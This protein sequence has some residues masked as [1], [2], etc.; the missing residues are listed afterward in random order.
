M[1]EAGPSTE[2]GKLPSPK[3][4]ISETP[5]QVP[6]PEAEILETP[7]NAEITPSNPEI[8]I[9]AVKVRNDW[10]QLAELANTIFESE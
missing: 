10:Q 9:K 4:E 8:R 2:A 1:G 7:S 5:S 3:A 6:S